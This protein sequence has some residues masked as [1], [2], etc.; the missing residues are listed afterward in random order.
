M[1]D[2][3]IKKHRPLDLLRRIGSRSAIKKKLV[4]RGISDDNCQIDFVQVG[5]F[6]CFVPN[7][8]F[9]SNLNSNLSLRF[10]SDVS[11][12]APAPSLVPVPTII[13]R[14]TRDLDRVVSLG[15][16]CKKLSLPTSRIL[17]S[18]AHSTMVVTSSLGTRAIHD[19]F[20]YRCFSCFHLIRN[21]TSPVRYRC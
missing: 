9:N 14:I 13:S 2:S 3:P 10:G 21:C 12:G 7:P 16:T 19:K 15:V 11:T 4:F 1:Q 17:T 18:Q 5:E 8:S 20:C 6:K